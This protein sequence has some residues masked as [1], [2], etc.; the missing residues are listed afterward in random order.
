MISTMTLTMILYLL[1]AVVQ[2]LQREMMIIIVM[3]PLFQRETVRLTAHPTTIII[4]MS[5]DLPIITTIVSS[6]ALNNK[7]TMMMLYQAGN[8]M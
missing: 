6:K 5:M 1:V 7:P 3:D 2:R 8:G 4:I